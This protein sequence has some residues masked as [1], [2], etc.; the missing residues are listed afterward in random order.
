MAVIQFQIARS[1]SRV[2]KPTEDYE[3]LSIF[4][5]DFDVR[6]FFESSYVIIIFQDL[7]TTTSLSEVQAI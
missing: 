2:N 7:S 6:H 5:Q 4:I 3:L 1:L